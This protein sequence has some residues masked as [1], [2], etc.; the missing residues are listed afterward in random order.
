MTASR[1]GTLF[2]CAAAVL[3]SIGGLCIKVI[4]W[5]GMS[6]NGGRT[7]IAL[8]VIGGYLIWT[9][10]P[11]RLNRWVLLG[12][13]SVFGTNALFSVANKL[14]T[15]ANAI[16]LQFTVPIFVMLFSALFFRKRPGRLD[17][18]ACAVIFGGVLFFFVDSLSMGGGLGNLIALLSGVSYAGVFLM[19]DMPN[20]DA[21][22]SVFWGDVLSALAGLPFLLRETQFTRTAL[23]SL[24]V[25]GVFQ[26]GVAYVC[27]CIGLKTTP[28]VTASLVSGIEPV[29]NPILVAL[30]YGERIGGFAMVGAAVVIVGVVGY[31]VLK[32]RQSREPAR[33]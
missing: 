27:L 25:L 17:L 9:R 31:N 7:A 12:A 3:Y 29:L 30:F 15:A 21:I 26:V 13:L 33:P 23:V 20:G 8:L 22:S 28:P 10:H 14:T 2:V 19:N 16:V 5:N 32:G 1:R 6:I 18:A 24:V 4:P 11:L